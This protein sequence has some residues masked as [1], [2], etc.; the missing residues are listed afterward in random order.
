MSSFQAIT[1]ALTILFSGMLLAALSDPLDQVIDSVTNT[2]YASESD[3]AYTDNI[4]IFK[5]IFLYLPI[6]ILGMIAVYGISVSQK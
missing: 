2:G 1:I 4:R 5:M 3:L 6:P